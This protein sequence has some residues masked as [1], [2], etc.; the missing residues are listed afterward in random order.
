MEVFRDLMIVVEA[1]VEIGLAVAVPIVQY[2]KLIPADQMNFP[3][4][5][6]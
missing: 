3:C 1:F 2:D 5:D 4:D 6:F